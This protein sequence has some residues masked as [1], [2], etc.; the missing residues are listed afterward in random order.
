M[1]LQLKKL[2]LSKFRGVHDLEITF[3]P[4]E[5]IISGENGCGKSTIYNAWLWL[6]SGKDAQDRKDF[7]IKPVNQ[8]G[9]NLF[10]RP[11]STVWAEIEVDGVVNTLSRTFS[12]KWQKKRGSES[13]EFTGHETN[14]TFNEVP[15]SQS[16]FQKKV[17][18]IVSDETFKILSNSSFFNSLAWGKR[19]T[20]LTSII[21]DVQESDVIREMKKAK[22]SGVDDL[23]K[24]LSEGKNFAE[25][26][27]ITS[28]K[29]KKLN[30]ELQGIAPRISE[31]NSKLVDESKLSDYLQVKKQN[32]DI[33]KS[34]K[35]RLEN[36][37]KSAN[38]E[39]EYKANLLT[40]KIQALE[41][42]QRDFRIDVWK[43]LN[44][45]Y[46]EFMKENSRLYEELTQLNTDLNTY[47]SSIAKLQAETTELL[48]KREVLVEKFKI[49]SSKKFEIGEGL[50]ECPTCKREFDHEKVDELVNEARS[51]FNENK[52]KKIALI[53]EDGKGIKSQ[54][55]RNNSSIEQLT[56]NASK[57][58]ESITY[59]TKKIQSITKVDKPTD[60]DLKAEL[61]KNESYI[62]KDLEIEKLKAEIDSLRVDEQQSDN[63]EILNQIDACNA[64]LAENLQN[65]ARIE[66][67]KEIH[68][69]IEELKK[70]ES[71]LTKEIANLEKVEYAIK[72]YDFFY[73]KAIEGQINS[74]FQTVKFKLFDTQVNGEIVTCCDTLVNGVNFGSVNNSG[75]INAGLEIISVLSN[76][77]NTFLPVFVDNAEAVNKVLS[78]DSQTI[79]LVVTNET[80][81]IK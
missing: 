61:L 76:H 43:G 37:Q 63:S 3:N 69:R 36:P 41:G 23:E 14:F 65:I 11:E 52:A 32:E 13:A 27:A 29:R 16:E 80:L 46:T 8:H 54:I 5:T 49:E 12:E 31:N 45:A 7:N 22:I 2:K 58:T 38:K 78:I 20:I 17:D 64:V 77:Y 19:R 62:E 40:A 74:K 75:Q 6:L 10:D 73:S 55:E 79:K 51:N 42:K 59:L 44:F 71:E 50:T 81:T 56:E 72:K 33:F 66:Q 25:I 26:K 47:N 18:A 53:N 15:L 21:P 68:V 39:L 28:N 4:Q 35:Q 48:A 67:N 70:R 1:R 24:Y 30:E 57:I 60:E 34:T 9:V